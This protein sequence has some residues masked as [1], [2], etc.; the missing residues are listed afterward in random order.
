MPVHAIAAHLVIVLAPMTAV[1]ALVYASAPTARRRLRL[2]LVVATL[3]S[4]G[5]VTWAGEAGGTLLERVEAE[6]SASE[7]AAATAHGKGSDALAVAVFVLL[8]LVLGFAWSL[9][10]PGRLPGTAT[11]LA[12]AVLVVSSVAVLATTWTTLASA[13]GA[14]WDHHPAWTG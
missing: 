11:R 9:L 5:L 6:G 4:A 10:R 14:V 2:P 12:T 8:G 1:L 13:L 3:V 7:V